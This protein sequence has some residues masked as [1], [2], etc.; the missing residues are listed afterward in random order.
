MIPRYPGIRGPSSGGNQKNA[1]QKTSPIKLEKC[2]PFRVGF[3]STQNHA[4][5]EQAPAVFFI[6]L[7]LANMAKD[8]SIEIH[9]L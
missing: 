8:R 1:T 3:C 7:F 2:Q 4:N 9:D 5:E 6:V